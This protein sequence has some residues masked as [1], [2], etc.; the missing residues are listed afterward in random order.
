MSMVLLWLDIIDVTT[1]EAG[2]IGSGKYDT[3]FAIKTVGMSD[4]MS[5]EAVASN[6]HFPFTPFI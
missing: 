2:A 1:H 4:F 5:K 3:P 6:I